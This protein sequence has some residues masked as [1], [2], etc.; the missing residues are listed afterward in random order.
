MK[1]YKWVTDKMQAFHDGYQFNFGWNEQD[2]IRDG[3]VCRDGGFHITIDPDRVWCTNNAKFVP[4][5][6]M[7]CHCYEV[8]YRK[9][10]VL[11]REGSKVRVKAFK[12][13]KKKP[14][15]AD[16]LRRPYFVGGST[17]N[18]TYTASDTSATSGTFSGNWYY[19]GAA[20]AGASC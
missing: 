7:M 4:D 19:Y 11:G 6:Q 20:N 5:G 13:Y 1:A 3:T 8:Y 10:D 17:Y 12:I 9:K 16:K 18:I 2:G 15:H 14:F